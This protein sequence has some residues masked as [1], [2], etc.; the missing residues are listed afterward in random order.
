M[1][2]FLQ[3]NESN[4]YRATNRNCEPALLDGQC[5]YP[6]REHL[7]V[8]QSKRSDAACFEEASVLDAMLLRIVARSLNFDDDQVLLGKKEV[9]DPIQGRV[10]PL[11]LPVR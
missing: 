5:R 10:E 6:S 11:L 8:A 9:S 3:G 1:I 2:I 7:F 4:S